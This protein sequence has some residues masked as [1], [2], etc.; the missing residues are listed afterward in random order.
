MH[1][2]ELGYKY[3]PLNIAPWAQIKCSSQ[4]NSHFSWWGMM[5][6]IVVSALPRLV[7]VWRYILG[8]RLV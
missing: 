8:G 1:F 7:M 5:S 3:L 2:S 4:K 6:D